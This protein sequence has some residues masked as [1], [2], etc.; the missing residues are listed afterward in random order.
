[1]NEFRD[2]RGQVEMFE[3][4]LKAYRWKLEAIKSAEIDS[5][6]DQKMMK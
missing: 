3:E 5:K 6:Y 4:I 2:L 1:M